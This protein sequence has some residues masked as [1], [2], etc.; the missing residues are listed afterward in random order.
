MREKLIIDWLEGQ[1][2]GERGITLTKDQLHLLSRF[3]E[4]VLEK[5]KKMNLTAITSDEDFAVKHFID[6]FTLLSFLP[7]G[8]F[9]LLDI[10][11]GAGFPGVP[12]KIAR[13]DLHLVLLDSVGKRIDFLQDALETLGVKAEY[14]HTRAED[15]PRLLPGVLFD[16][17]TAR[18]VARLDKLC[19]YA[20][21]LLDTDGIFL[22]MKGPDVAD[23]LEE[24][25]DALKKYGGVVREVTCPLLEDK[26]RHTIV[27]IEKC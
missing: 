5:N 17:I 26:L 20:L 1:R 22:A 8:K 18:A 7:Q 12:L 21:P 27:V 10:G 3:Q 2:T 16:V 24:A 11:T 14:L 4:L 23:E 9:S 15:I 25:A 6:S 19:K 13:P